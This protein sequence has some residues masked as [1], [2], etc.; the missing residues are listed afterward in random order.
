[1]NKRKMNDRDQNTIL[2]F[3]LETTGL[4]PKNKSYKDL[5]KWP[6]IVQ[7]SWVLFDLNNLKIISIQDY[8]IKCPIKIPSQSTKI[9][10]ISDDISQKQGKE[11]DLVMDLFEKDVNQ[12]N[13]VIAHN[14][15]FDKSVYIAESLR[16]DKTN[17]FLNKTC[18]CTMMN[19]IKLCNIKAISKSGKQYT[20]YPKL[21]ELHNHIFKISD[22]DQYNLHNS[23]VDVILCLKCYIKLNLGID[24]VD[25]NKELKNLLKI[26]N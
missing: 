6:H 19:N 4:T 14:I 3:D 17:P 11:L 16:K 9:H 8:I 1:M 12:C 7:I 13:L 26:R 5:N 25:K 2:V 15:A 20:K 10:K 24:I 18:Y 21:I 23:L 22:I